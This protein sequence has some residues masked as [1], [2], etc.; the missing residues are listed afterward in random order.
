MGYFIAGQ[1]IQV[2]KNFPKYYVMI[3][4]IFKKDLTVIMCRTRTHWFYNG[5]NSV[6]IDRAN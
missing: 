2:L 3:G 1:K 5:Q 6:S 4:T